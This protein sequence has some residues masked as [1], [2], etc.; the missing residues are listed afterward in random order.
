MNRKPIIHPILFLV[1]AIF[2]MP[3]VFPIGTHSLSE[4]ILQPGLWIRVSLIEAEK[5]QEYFID[6]K[7]LSLENQLK[8]VRSNNPKTQ[9]IL[10]E[11]RRF[12]P[13][14][15]SKPVQIEFS[16]PLRIPL[17][18]DETAW[19]E[20]RLEPLQERFYPGAVRW[21]TRNGNEEKEI[22]KIPKL[23]WNKDRCLLLFNMG[24]I[25]QDANDFTLI[26]VEFVDPR[27]LEEQKSDSAN[28]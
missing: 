3:I 6:K 8:Q 13:L 20:I 23:K 24:E 1:M 25:N 5:A 21:F 4:I 26:A 15:I 27:T 7:I 28:H 9:E 10:R 19:L 22:I 18:K 12:T 11:F 14:W 17:D 2:L 16:N